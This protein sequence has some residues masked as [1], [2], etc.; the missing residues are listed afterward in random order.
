MQYLLLN[1]YISS[2]GMKVHMQGDAICAT[3][4][5]H[6]LYTPSPTLLVLPL[7]SL[8]ASL[9]VYLPLP[10]FNL[11]LSSHYLHANANSLSTKDVRL[12]MFSISPTS[13]IQI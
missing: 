5:N 12:Y 9:T 4:M 6:M 8:S 2:Y 1:N 11:L 10:S 13:V 7:C 3:V